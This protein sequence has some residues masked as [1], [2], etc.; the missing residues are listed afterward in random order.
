MSFSHS[1]IKN[2]GSP[3]DSIMSVRTTDF[4]DGRLIVFDLRTAGMDTQNAG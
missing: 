3:S 1:R 2:I 4:V